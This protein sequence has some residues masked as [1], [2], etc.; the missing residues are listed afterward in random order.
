MPTPRSAGGIS[1]MRLSTD[2]WTP[3][4]SFRD[5]DAANASICR[6]RMARQTPRTLL[7]IEVDIFFDTTTSPQAFVTLRSCTFAMPFPRY[8]LSPTE[9]FK[10]G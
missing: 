7:D 8:N 2:E 6:S 3:L 5:R 9:T 4:Q 1:F 10:M